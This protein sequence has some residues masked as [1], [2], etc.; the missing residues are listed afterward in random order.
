MIIK[1]I[2][3]VNYDQTIENGFVE[4]KNGKIINIGK[5]YQGLEEA[6]EGEY[7]LPGFIDIHTHGTNGFDVMDAT[8]EAL[9]SMVL[10][11]PKEGVTSFLATTLTMSQDKLIA[12]IKNVVDYKEDKTGASILGI[13]LEGPYVNCKYKGAQNE[14]Y[15]QEASEESFNELLKHA[16]GF[17]KIVTYA[18]ELTKVQFTDYLVKNNIIPSAGHSGASMACILEHVEHGLKNITHFH[19]G[20]SG[21]HHR[22]PGV[23][24][25]GLYSDDISVEL[26]VDGHH[27][28][29]DVVKLVHKLKKSDHIFLITDSMRA[30]N[31]EDGAYSLG[32]L[33]VVKKNGVVR[34][35]SGGLAGSILTMDNAVKNM[36]EFTACSMNEI[37]SMTSY[38]QAK[39]LGLSHNLGKIAPGYKA[40]LLVFDKELNLTHTICKGQVFSE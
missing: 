34:T 24:S 37:V 11:L 5:D 2:K 28:D 23:V 40:D 29:K 6:I 20:Q 33:D 32:G 10:K 17:I 4:I 31:L 14:D 30:K 8:K 19:N 21:H 39:L 26:I 35:S 3:I 12:A 36:T 27:I 1:N 22:H 7:L 25:A 15:I 9:D 38:N 16:N 18:P 13:H